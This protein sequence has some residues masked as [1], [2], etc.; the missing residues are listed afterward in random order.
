MF[1][2][3]LNVKNTVRADT[4]K[5]KPSFIYIFALLII[6]IIGKKMKRPKSTKI[7]E[8]DSSSG[9]ESEEEVS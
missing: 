6:L 2:I 9:S 8:S 3:C 7:I 4:R 5:F 1:L